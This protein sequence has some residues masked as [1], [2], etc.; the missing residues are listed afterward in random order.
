MFRQK[1]I[2]L[3]LLTYISS[4]GSAIS[5]E[6]YFFC[7][8]Q[9]FKYVDGWVTDKFFY[10]SNGE[11]VDYSSDSTFTDDTIIMPGWHREM[12]GKRCEFKKVFFLVDRFK[13]KNNTTYEFTDVVTSPSC[14]GSDDCNKI[15]TSGDKLSGG[16]CSVLDK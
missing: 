8:G 10:N 7:N 13:F 16:L 1:I 3:V 4:V 15:F 5:S 6:Q 14:K 9:K 11:W 12:C 2:L